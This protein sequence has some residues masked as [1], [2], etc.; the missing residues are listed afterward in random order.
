MVP[1]RGGE[2][3]TVHKQG[4][5]ALIGINLDFRLI[6]RPV[7]VTGAAKVDERL[8]FIPVSLIQVKRVFLRLPVDG[9]EALLVH[10]V[11]AALVPAVRG[12]IKHIPDMSGPEVRAGFHHFQHMLMIDAL[13]GLCV[14][15]LF[16]MA[17]LKRGIGIGAVFGEAD[18]PVGIFCVIFVKKLLR[19]LQFSQV[20]AEIQVVAVDVRNFQNGRIDFQ[21]ENVGH[22]GG[23]GGIQSMAEVVQRPVVFQQ[24]FI[25]RAGGG[26]LVGKPPADDGRMVVILCDQLPHL[27]EGIFPAVFHMH[28]NVGNFRPGDDTIFIAEVVE[29]LRVLIMRQTNRVGTDF[30][31][32]RHVLPVH[33]RG[34]GIPHTQAV[35]V[36]RDAAKRIG[37]VI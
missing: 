19:L 22:C 18:D 20:P 12:E 32:Q 26:N 9:H 31:D 13:I 21:H 25:H 17:A 23:A 15:S 37:A 28:G 34:Q 7:H 8:C 30:P 24:I 14:I 29:F 2:F 6:L 27:G 16:G 10:A 1:I 11:F 4:Y 33:I 36:T 5:C 3:L 35:L